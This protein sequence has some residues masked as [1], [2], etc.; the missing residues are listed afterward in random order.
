MGKASCMRS[1]RYSMLMMC[2]VPLPVFW[3]VLACDD[4]CVN[5]VGARWFVAATYAECAA[6]TG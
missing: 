4:W 5:T 1:T 6:Y 3:D 2:P